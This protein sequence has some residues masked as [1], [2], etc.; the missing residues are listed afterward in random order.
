[1]RHVRFLGPAL[2]TAILLA[3]CS[4]SSGT[5]PGANV[6]PS[7]GGVL[8]NSAARVATVDLL[9]DLAQSEPDEQGRPSRIYVNDVSPE[10]SAG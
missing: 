10:W 8:P 7:T 5:A 3:A 9:H 4:G 6:S 2:A 1:M